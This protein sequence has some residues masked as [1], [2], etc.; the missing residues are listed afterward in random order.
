MRDRP[1]AEASIWQHT[2]LTTDIHAPGGIRPAVP[3]SERPQAH[4]LDRAAAGIGMY[5]C[6][7][8]YVYVCIYIYIYISYIG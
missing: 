5:V 6:V 3:V 2:T 1:V 8:V 4:A 7:C